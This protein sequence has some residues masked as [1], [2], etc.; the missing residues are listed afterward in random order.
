MEQEI[1]VWA[2]ARGLLML[3]IPFLFIDM[4]F[5]YGFIAG[6]IGLKYI[7]HPVTIFLFSFLALVL[8]FTFTSKLVIK[9]DV[10]LFRRLI[11]P[12]FI[13][14]KSD[15]EYIKFNGHIIKFRRSFGPRV[16]IIPSNNQLILKAFGENSEVKDP[17]DQRTFMNKIVK[18][19]V[20]TTFSVLISSLAYEVMIN[21]GYLTAL[22]FIIWIIYLAIITYSV[23]YLM[24]PSKVKGSYNI[25]VLF[26]IGVFGLPVNAILLSIFTKTLHT[27][28]Y[29]SVIFSL[30]LGLLV[31]SLI[32]Y[33]IGK[34]F[35]RRGYVSLE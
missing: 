17:K 13:Y 3:L 33:Y 31:G 16:F 29:Y 19:V 25:W 28:L 2:I 11:F 35:I 4:L 6:L 10:V 7:F 27:S 22:E 26:G 30:L 15:L 24:S 8:F 23:N 32:G 14:S 34:S 21:F 9:D 12:D 18:Y 20:L 1:A 5:L